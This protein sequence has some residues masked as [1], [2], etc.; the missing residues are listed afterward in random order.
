[1]RTKFWFEISREIITWERE[2]LI[3]LL[4]LKY[5]VKVITGFSCLSLGSIGEIL[6][7]G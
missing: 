5:S 7:T 3:F 2:I 6:L 4:L 1:M